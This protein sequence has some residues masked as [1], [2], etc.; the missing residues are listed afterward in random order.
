MKIRFKE[1]IIAWC[2][3]QPMLTLKHQLC[4]M[5]KYIQKIRQ[6]LPTNCLSVFDHFVELLLKE[7]NDRNENYTK[8]STGQIQPKVN[9]CLKLKL[10]IN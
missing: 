5:V 4:K 7:L 8:P 6:L 9:K 3:Q 10:K 2:I 1:N